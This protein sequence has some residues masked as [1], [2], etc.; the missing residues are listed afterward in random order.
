MKAAL[1]QAMQRVGDAVT[2][3]RKDGTN[4]QQHFNYT[5]EALVK[6]EF[7][8][9]FLRHGILFF[10]N[11]VECS[12]E[13]HQS[14]ENKPAGYLTT[15]TLEITLT[16]MESGESETFRASGQG[17]DSTDKSVGKAYSYAIKTWLL[18]SFLVRTGEDADVDENG[19]K[20][21]IETIETVFADKL[22]ELRAYEVKKGSAKEKYAEILGDAKTYSGAPVADPREFKTRAEAMVCLAALNRVLKDW[23][24]ARL[25][26]DAESPKHAMLANDSQPGT[27][28]EEDQDSQKDLLPSQAK[29]GGGA[30]ALETPPGGLALEELTAPERKAVAD[31]LKAQGCKTLD[32]R[33]MFL[34]KWES[35][36]EDL[37]ER[38]GVT[39]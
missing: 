27:G 15:I 9:H 23:K 29:P 17:Y 38:A 31:W 18:N 24:T 34:D 21:E 35:T 28:G 33:R 30:K 2:Y 39:A 20:L 8:K 3:L 25:D 22:K 12:T 19:E 6:G 16:H 5:S 11:E 7:H 14:K 26:R 37:L 32:E 1:Y 36:K 13:R 10:C 4:Q